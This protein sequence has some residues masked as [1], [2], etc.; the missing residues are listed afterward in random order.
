MTFKDGE[1]MEG[2]LPNN[3][4]QVEAF[5]FSL[6]PPEMANIQRVY[7][8]RQALDLAEVLGVV[9]SPLRR[10]KAKETT[11]QIGLFEP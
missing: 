4:L 9:G 6:A 7:V 8:P 3:L 11:G 10:K 1:T 5:G 2:V